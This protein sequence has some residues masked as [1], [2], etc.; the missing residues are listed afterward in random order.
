MNKRMLR[1]FL[2]LA[3]LSLAAAHAAMV[4]GVNPFGDWAGT[5]TQSSNGTGGAALFH[6]Q[7]HGTAP[8]LAAGPTKLTYTETWA[9]AKSFTNLYL[10]T[11]RP[12]GGNVYIATTPGGPLTT[13]LTTFS[14]ATWNTQAWLP[15]NATAVYGVRVEVDDDKG[16]GF[17]QMGEVGFQ[18]QDI[19]TNVAFGQVDVRSPNY[20]PDGNA[21]SLIDGRLDDRP[22]QWRAGTSGS[23]CW[24]GFEFADGTPHS[25]GAL[26]LYASIQHGST[27]GWQNP[28]VQIKQEGVWLSL[29]Q[30]DSTGTNFY[31]IDFQG[32]LQVQGVR[33]YGSDALGNN[34]VRA[35]GGLIVDEL[36][37]FAV[38]EP[39]TL[40]LAGLVVAS[41]AAR[42]RARA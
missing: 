4:G 24:V 20:Y 17:Y 1:G 8:W 40:A 18:V 41:L 2:A 22:Y 25:V 16:T 23:E 14:V 35:G 11:S 28:D 39:A 13:L 15:V 27:W 32:N 34:P 7:N 26:R 38:P 33:L 31:W 19:P 3:F 21:N 12:A 6:D 9:A 42:R 30:I 5:G 10:F 36:E 37:A 29:G